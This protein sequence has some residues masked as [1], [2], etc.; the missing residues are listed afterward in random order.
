M[1]IIFKKK[2]TPNNLILI[3]NERVSKCRR[4]PHRSLRQLR[5]LRQLR[6]VRYVRCVAYVACVALGGN[7]ALHTARSRL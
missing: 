3:K 2:Q 4:L 5:H 1:N 7:S 6:Y